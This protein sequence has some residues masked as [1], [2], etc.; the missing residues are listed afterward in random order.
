MS[1]K[2]LEIHL[3]VYNEET[4]LPKMLDCLARQTRTDFTVVIHDNG[5]TDKTSVICERAAENDSRFRINR[6]PVNTG[7]LAQ[8]MR[9]RFGCSADFVSPRSANDRIADNYVDATLSLLEQDDSIALAYSHGYLID[10]DGEIVGTPRDEDRIDTRGLDTPLQRGIHVMQR[11]GF[12]FP[13]WGVY[14]RR[15]LETTRMPRFSYGNDH[16]EVCEIALYGHVVSTSERLDFRQIT[17]NE[18]NFFP[19][20]VMSWSRQ[21]SEEISRGVAEI[22]LYGPFAIH[23]PFTNMIWGHIDMFSVAR[24]DEQTKI[25]LSREAVSIFCARFGQ[26]LKY[27]VDAFLAM[28]NRDLT[29]FLSELRTMPNEA[30]FLR[31]GKLK[32]ELNKL[33]IIP[34]VPKNEIAAI[35]AALIQHLG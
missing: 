9:M 6:I 32:V 29:K 1:G 8:G 34:F 4:R 3:P 18:M 17:S 20:G 12:S 33:N 15:V 13:L 30:R 25:A 28:V 31:L 2:H 5:S 23:L 22:S 26:Y 27:E 10:E 11:Y 24:I 35:E 7:T 16:V 14:R 21:Y 19:D